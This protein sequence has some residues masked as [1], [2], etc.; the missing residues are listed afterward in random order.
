[1]ASIRKSRKQFK[2]T[3][4]YLKKKKR[5]LFLTTSNRWPGDHEKP[6]ST[7]LAYELRKE[8]GK[9]VKIFEIPKMKIYL[10]EGNVSTSR[11]NRCG[12]QEA[13]LKDK[14]KNPTG[15]HRCFASLNNKDD[16]L[17]KISRELFRSDAVVF[18]GSIRWGQAD[19]TYQRLIERLT[20]IEN[21]HS[22]LGEKNVVSNIDAG[23]IFVGEN[24]RG[25]KVL[26]TQ[27]KVLDFF[28]FHVV[29]DLSWNWQYEKNANDESDES[30]RRGVKEFSKTFSVRG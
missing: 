26:K 20:W 2:K 21:R 29:Q 28:G 3:L 17:W 30:Y 1:M 12:L 10:C 7:Q 27:K 13:I 22:T 23:V 4:A 19:A 11:G 14:R 25:K 15:F 18:F 6:K 24:W 16:E 5:I 9:K 8:L